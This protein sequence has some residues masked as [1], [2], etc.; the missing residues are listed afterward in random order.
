MKPHVERF[1]ERIL[2]EAGNAKPPGV[3]HGRDEICFSVKV[4]WMWNGKTHAFVLVELQCKLTCFLNEKRWKWVA[5]QCF[6]TVQKQKKNQYS[7]I[8]GACCFT[9]GAWRWTRPLLADC[10]WS[11]LAL[12][13]RHNSTVLW[14]EIC[15]YQCYDQ[16]EDD[17]TSPDWPP[18]KSTVMIVV[19]YSCG[20]DHLQAALLTLSLTWHLIDADIDYRL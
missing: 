19:G 15:W 2:K 3:W 14:E 12:S 11:G 1:S 9:P 13:P 6:L 16:W 17:R 8:L 5:R 18:S 10:F 20:L 7:E 4:T